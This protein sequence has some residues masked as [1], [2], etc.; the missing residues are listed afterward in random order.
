MY[1]HRFLKLAHTISIHFLFKITFDCVNDKFTL[2]YRGPFSR[3]F[4]LPGK[5]S[6][7][8]FSL[9]FFGVYKFSKYQHPFKKI[10]VYVPGDQSSKG[11]PVEVII[12]N[13]R[14]DLR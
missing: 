8:K 13:R 9:A 2:F 1:L 14:Y 7:G 10:F 3:G 12:A 4:I 11:F 6:G 5:T